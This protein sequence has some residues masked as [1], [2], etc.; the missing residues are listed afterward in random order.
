MYN[1]R[2]RDNVI[3]F[4]NKTLETNKEQFEKHFCYIQIRHN[5]PYGL[6]KKRVK[7]VICMCT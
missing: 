7:K 3:Y 1:Y 4:A 2:L 6:L 5:M